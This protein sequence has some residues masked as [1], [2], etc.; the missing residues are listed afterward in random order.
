ML[1][2]VGELLARQAVPNFVDN[3]HGVCR[4]VDGSDIPHLIVGHLTRP[5]VK[6]SIAYPDAHPRAAGPVTVVRV[7]MYFDRIDAV[8]SLAKHNVLDCT[9]GN[10]VHIQLRIVGSVADYTPVGVA[11]PILTVIRDRPID[12]A[13]T[14][15]VQVEV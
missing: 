2:F 5:E 13:G 14:N 3:G 9:G 4:P 11:V 15:E 6:L 7:V 8:E 10:A 12:A 1:R